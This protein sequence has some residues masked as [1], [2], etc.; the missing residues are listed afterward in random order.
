MLN[1]ESVC[2]MTNREK[3]LQM[4]E[5]AIGK[6]LCNNRKTFAI[7]IGINERNLSNAL[8]EK[9]AERFCTNSLIIKANEALGFPFSQEWVIG[10]GEIIESAEEIVELKPSNDLAE[11]EKRIQELEYVIELQKH[12]IMQL[13][14]ECEQLKKASS[15]AMTHSATTA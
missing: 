14:Q 4:Y 5:Y 15:I 2:I 11:L 7:L 12:R 3:L 13:E 8:S 10:D 1:L 6:S 9:Y